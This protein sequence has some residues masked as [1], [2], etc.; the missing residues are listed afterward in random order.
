MNPCNRSGNTLTFDHAGILNHDHFFFK[1][2]S[3]YARLERF[4]REFVASVDFDS[5]SDS[6]YFY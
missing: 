2:W 4:A 6:D 3:G 5:N 1:K